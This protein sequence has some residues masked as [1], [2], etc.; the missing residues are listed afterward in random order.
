MNAHSFVT[1]PFMFTEKKKTL[2]HR[3]MIAISNQI[4]KM[5]DVKDDDRK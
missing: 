3:A 1:A 5:K 4:E 2:D